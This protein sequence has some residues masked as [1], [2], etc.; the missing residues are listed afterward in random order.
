M[1]TPHM[2][3][4][5]SFKISV[6]RSSFSYLSNRKKSRYIYQSL[7]SHPLHHLLLNFLHLCSMIPFMFL[8]GSWYFANNM[9]KATNFIRLRYT[10]MAKHKRTTEI[11]WKGVKL[12]YPWLYFLDICSI[13]WK[14]HVNTVFLLWT[15]QH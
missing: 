14:A 6:S 2:L 4:A 11:N 12:T 1:C 9:R 5:W 13:R 8:V 3:A 15:Q 10:N 7:R